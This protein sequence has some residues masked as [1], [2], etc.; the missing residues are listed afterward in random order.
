ME[1]PKLKIILKEF[2]YNCSDGCCTNYGTITSVNGNEL[3]CRNQDTET[4]IT[5]ILEH[6]GYEVEVESFFEED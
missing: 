3:P 6:L 4:I 2:S 5:Q 1:K